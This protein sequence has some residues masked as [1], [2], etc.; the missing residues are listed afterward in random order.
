MLNSRLGTF[1]GRVVA[2]F[3]AGSGALGL[4]ALSRGAAHCTFIERDRAALAALARNIEILGAGPRADVRPGSLPS[5]LPART[6]DLALIDPP[7]ADHG[8]A[9]VLAA[10]V[11]RHLLNAG[12]WVSIETGQDQWPAHDG[13]SVVTT[14]DVGKARLTLLHRD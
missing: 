6:L 9:A 14:R 10:L 1:S 2:D 12:A 8:W 5:S 7:Y 4:E 3:Y 11:D 13:F